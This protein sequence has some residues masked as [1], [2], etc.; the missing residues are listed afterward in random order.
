MCVCTCEY[1]WHMQGHTPWKARGHHQVF[2]IRYY[3]P[4]DLRLTSLP[5][6]TGQPAPTTGFLHSFTGIAYMCRQSLA[7]YMDAGKLSSVSCTCVAR[8]LL[9]EL[10]F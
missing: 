5:R 6:L 3:L 9:T 4:R 10:S 7:F 8:S 1:V 2:V